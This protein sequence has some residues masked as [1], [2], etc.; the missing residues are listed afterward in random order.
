[1][2]SAVSR[3]LTVVTDADGA[4]TQ[5]SYDG[6]NRLSEVYYEDEDRT[7]SY[8]YDAVGNRVAMT[9][10]LGVTS[11]VYDDMYRLVEVDDPIT[12]TVAYEYDLAGNRT[13]LIYPNG[14][15]VTHTY[16]ADNRP[17]RVEDWDG[18]ATTYAYD[19]AGRAVTTTMPNGVTTVDAY[20]EAGRLVRHKHTTANETVLA[21]YQYVLDGLG[22]R[23]GATETLTAT[24]TITQTYDKL[25]R[26]TGS[27]YSTGESFAYTY[28]AVGNREVMTSVTP[29]SGTVVTTYTFPSAIS[30]Q[31]TPRTACPPRGE[32]R[33]DVHLYVVE[34][35]ADAGRVDERRRRAHVHLHFGFAKV[36]ATTPGR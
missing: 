4:V 23:T 19:A 2:R 26:L 29:I 33:A 12:G 25:N 24:R 32:R 27:A 31:V 21:D 34:P 9:D 3:R 11:Y 15:V 7:V 36:Q 10:T 5:H 16:D 20:D 6:L 18:G 28:D 14:Q 30:G 1:M 13:Q 35:G 22:N 8:E 17:I